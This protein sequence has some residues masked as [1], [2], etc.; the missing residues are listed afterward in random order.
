M[1]ERQRKE[2]RGRKKLRKE[3]KACEMKERGRKRKQ[4]KQRNQR[5]RENKTAK[6]VR[7][8]SGESSREEAFGMFSFIQLWAFKACR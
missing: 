5:W 2:T 3:R 8:G 6:K 1:T 7:E 4:E